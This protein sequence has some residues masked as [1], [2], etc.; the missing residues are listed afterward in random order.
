MLGH[1]SPPLPSHRDLTGVE[2]LALYGGIGV[3][4]DGVETGPGPGARHASEDT[5]S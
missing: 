4:G 1:K 3:V 2:G 5:Q